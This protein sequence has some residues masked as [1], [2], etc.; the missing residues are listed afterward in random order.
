MFGCS[1]S[2]IPLQ[3][4]TNDHSHSFHHCGYIAVDSSTHFQVDLKSIYGPSIFFG[5]HY[6][7]LGLCNLL[8]RLITKADG[9]RQL[10]K[11][12]PS[13][14]VASLDHPTPGI[15][16]LEVSADATASTSVSG[17]ESAGGQWHSVRVSG[18]SEVD[19]YPGFAAN[20]LP[21]NH[22]ASPQPIE[23]TPTFHQ[24]VFR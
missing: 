11:T 1:S 14:F 3:I 17:D 10:M 7:P 8:G 24:L 20:P 23:G 16:S 4:P 2:E 19:F 18:I 21:Y 12:V 6:P 5:N 15:W 22:G 13:V 9:L